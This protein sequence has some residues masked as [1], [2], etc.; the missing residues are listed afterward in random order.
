M[1]DTLG[2]PAKTGQGVRATRQDSSGGSTLGGSSREAKPLSSLSSASKHQPFRARGR[3][4]ALTCQF[5]T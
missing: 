1:G 3:K 5:G 2:T 4:R